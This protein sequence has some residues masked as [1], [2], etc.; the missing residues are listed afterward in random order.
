MTSGSPVEVAEPISPELVLVA[1]PEAADIARAE[2]PDRTPSFSAER[3]AA[4][5]DDSVPPDSHGGRERRPLLRLLLAAA[6]LVLG[7]LA[8]LF[9]VMRGDDGSTLAAA[10]SL[11]G[12]GNNPDHPEWG[13]TG[14][15]YVRVAKPNFADGAGRMVT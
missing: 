11:D 7:A 6:A 4:P 10:R 14:A 9:F 3:T 5:T 2:L 13:E 1:P 15:P 12:S 8:A